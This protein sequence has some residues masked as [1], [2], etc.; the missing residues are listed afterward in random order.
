MATVG[1]DKLRQ[2]HA[3]VV[4]QVDQELP[5]AAGIVQ[6]DQPAGA[7]RV[8]LREHDERRGELVHV[9]DALHAVAVEQRLVAGVLARNRA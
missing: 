5:L 3:G 9:V 1:S 7:V 6:R 8:R 2:R 4:R